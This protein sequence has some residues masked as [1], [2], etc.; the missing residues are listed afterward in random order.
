M[1]KL[2]LSILSVT[3]LTFLPLSAAANYPP[4][5]KER[6]EWC[7][8]WMPHANQTNLPHVLLIGDSI[9]RAYYPLV[10]KQL[11]GTAYVDRLTTSAFIA[12]PML[13]KEIEMVLESQ[14]YAVIQ[15]N[16]GLHGASHPVAEYRASF[17]KFLATI[18]EH[19]RGA[20]LIWADTTPLKEVESAAI[21][22]PSAAT[23]QG[24]EAGRLMLRG[25]L[26][27]LSNARVRALNAI[28]LEFVKP[29]GI[30]VV[31][32]N[33]PM[34]GHPEYHNGNVHFNAQGMKIQAD[35]VAAE[36]QSVL[37]GTQH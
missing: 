17:P 34:V 9:T 4:S 13:L 11:A 21:G 3:S 12:D 19:A 5:A 27:D 2:I 28:A 32:L 14:K 35:M 24:V 25:D 15:F 16:N 37:N 7:D 29:L 20:K 33:T 8:I 10:D 26:T 30:P 23:D 36:V 22:E 18:R 31:D 1:I 6:I